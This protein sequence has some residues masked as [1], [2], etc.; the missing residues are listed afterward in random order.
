MWLASW[1]P[2]ESWKPLS[3]RKSF[4]SIFLPYVR[5]AGTG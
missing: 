3:L 4:L 5:K 2:P 1:M